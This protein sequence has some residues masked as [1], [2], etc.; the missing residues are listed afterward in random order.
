V[1]DK[2]PLS[3]WCALL[4]QTELTVNLL[5]QSNAVPKISVFAHVHD[6]HDYM[7][8]P[9]APIGCAVQ[10]HAK[11]TNRQTW[12]THTEAG[13]NLGTS[14]EHH[15]CFKIYVPKTRATRVSNTVFFKHQY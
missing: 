14:M 5:R 8:K 9:F 13:Y 11:P 3:L 6:Q 2:F 7:K 12:D 4:E 15:R 10:V 1:D